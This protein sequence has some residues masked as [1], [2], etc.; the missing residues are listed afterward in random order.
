MSTTIVKKTSIATMD[1]IKRFI[2]DRIRENKGDSFW[3]DVKIDGEFALSNCLCL[4]KVSYKY[5]DK[6]YN[7]NKELYDECASKNSYFNDA[8]KYTLMQEVYFKKALGIFSNNDSEDISY[9]LKMTYKKVN[10]LIKNSDDIVYL[11]NLYKNGDLMDMK[12]GQGFLFSAIILAEQVGKTV[13]VNDFAYSEIEKSIKNN[14][15]RMGA[16]SR[17]SISNMDKDRRK[18]L[19]NIQLKVDKRF[20]LLKYASCDLGDGVNDDDIPGLEVTIKS[21]DIEKIMKGE[22]SPLS[23]IN[24][25]KVNEIL[26][27]KA[28]ESHHM[29]EAISAVFD[30]EDIDYSAIVKNYEIKPEEMQ[31]LLNAYSLVES[32][33][34]DIDYNKLYDFLYASISV[35]FLLKTYKE[36]K[37]QY[38][39]SVRELERHNI[40]DKDKKLS[41]IQQENLNTLTKYNKLK[42]DTDNEID[43][44]K[45]EIRILKSKNTQ[46]E[47]MHLNNDND[48]EEITQLR[49]LMFELSIDEDEINYRDANTVD[50]DRLNNLNA[51]CLGGLNNWISSMKEKLP[52]WT[53][54]A[55][56]VENYDPALLKGRDYIFINTKANTHGMYYRAIEN[57]DKNTKLRY[58]NNLNIDRVLQEIEKSL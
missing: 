29:M 15:S 42:E 19:R 14:F 52:N 41:I 10:Q 4:D 38:F 35:K 58:I 40:E 25:D 22:I 13:S 5:I 53:F 32:I 31:E 17:L 3:R 43:K 6:I 18:Y 20:P 56:G 2:K 28:K 36:T 54:V 49:N 33:D 44:L 48:K 34:E 37:T 50:L 26:D 55:A 39:K 8:K 21:G 1:A 51:I 24:M 9:I 12:E 57:K 11:S 47:K 16:K 30:L 23:L 7:K 45:E 27:S 46:L